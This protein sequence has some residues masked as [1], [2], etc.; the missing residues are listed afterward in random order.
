MR[1][2]DDQKIVIELERTPAGFRVKPEPKTVFVIKKNAQNPE[3]NIQ[4]KPVEIQP[5][6]KDKIDPKVIKPLTPTVQPQNGIK[7]KPTGPITSLDANPVTKPEEP[8]TLDGKFRVSLSNL[9]PVIIPTSSIWF[10]FSSIHKIEQ[11]SLPEFFTNSSTKTPNNYKI[12]RNKIL[13]MFHN[14]PNK[15]LTGLSCVEKLVN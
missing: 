15:Y 2:N 8:K 10:D 12:I 3:L 5:S 1:S 4:Q 14:S 9:N 13:E 11:E 7:P 6:Q